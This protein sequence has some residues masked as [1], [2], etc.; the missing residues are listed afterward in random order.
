LRK[1]FKLG[2]PISERDAV[3]PD[4]ESALTLEKPENLGPRHVEPAPGGPSEEE[5]EAELKSPPSEYQKS[6]VAAAAHLPSAGGAKEHIKALAA[7]RPPALIPIHRTKE[8]AALY[9]KGKVRGFLG[10]G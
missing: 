8:E 4:L 7:G 6:L 9:V 3:A 1:C 5:V 10:K 2:A